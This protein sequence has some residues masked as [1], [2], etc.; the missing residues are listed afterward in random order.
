MNK[1]AANSG[2]QQS[3]FNQS[4]YMVMKIISVFTKICFQ[5][6]QNRE[7]SEKKVE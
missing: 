4:D 6:Y 1:S 5:S 3:A 2:K 7:N